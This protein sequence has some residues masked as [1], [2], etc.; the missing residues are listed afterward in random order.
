MKEHHYTKGSWQAVTDEIKQAIG[1]N[2]LTKAQ[3][4]TIMSMYL[5]GTDVQKMIEI[6]KGGEK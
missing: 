4:S 5:T 2:C 1:I 3:A 6:L